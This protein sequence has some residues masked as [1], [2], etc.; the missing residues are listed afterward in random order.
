[1]Y[2]SRHPSAGRP[3]EAGRNDYVESPASEASK[4]QSV[5]LAHNCARLDMLFV[6]FCELRETPRHKSIS[7]S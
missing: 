5:S 6:D 3:S 1:M 7:N 2:R 4:P